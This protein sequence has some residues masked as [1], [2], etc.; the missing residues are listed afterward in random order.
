MIQLLLNM[1]FSQHT[2]LF[3]SAV[4]LGNHLIAEYLL[5]RGRVNLNQPDNE[6]VSSITYKT[7]LMIATVLNDQYLA[8][9]LCSR[10]D[11][12]LNHTDVTGSTAL[13]IAAMLGHHELVCFLSQFSRTDLNMPDNHGVTPLISASES[14]HV[15]IVRLLAGMQTIQLDAYDETGVSYSFI[16]LHCWQ[17]R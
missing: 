13:R 15:E 6:G 16:G 10:D 11:I 7:P 3:L 4:R 5:S 2:S 17:L 8:E 9:L 1:G 14:G 12:C